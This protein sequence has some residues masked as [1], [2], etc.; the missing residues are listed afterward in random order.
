M[1]G[2]SP[3]AGPLT[4][5]GTAG[6]WEWESGHTAPED[7]RA[8]DLPEL[9]QGRAGQLTPAQ[10]EGRS[11]RD[12]SRARGAPLRTWGPRV[13]ASA[14]AGRGGADCSGHL[15]GGGGEEEEEEIKW[16]VSAT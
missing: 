8:P 1:S 12:S 4:R 15:F 9:P 10:G 14:C 7:R 13:C 5:E 16:G 3:S 2:A 11:K 6:L